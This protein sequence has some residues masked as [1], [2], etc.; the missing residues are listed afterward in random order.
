MPSISRAPH[1]PRAGRKTTAGRSRS[2]TSFWSRTWLG[3]QHQSW[4]GARTWAPLKRAPICE[5]WCNALYASSALLLGPPSFVCPA[6][7]FF[8][9]QAA[10]RPEDV[11]G[12]LTKSVD[13]LSR[14]RRILLRRLCARYNYNQKINKR[15][16]IETC[17]SV[18]HPR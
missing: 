14:L 7:R 6:K 1:P 4:H 3:A 11:Q 5:R 9:Q 17:S 8:A 15:N 2:T 10:R 12:V 13:M 16:T 18:P